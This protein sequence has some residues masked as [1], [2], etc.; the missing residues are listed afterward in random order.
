MC[1]L[2]DK[3]PGCTAAPTVKC[4]VS[5]ARYRGTVLKA[6]AANVKGTARACRQSCEYAPALDVPALKLQPRPDDQDRV[7][8][9]SCGLAA[10]RRMVTH[11]SIELA[12]ASR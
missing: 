8:C 4:N 1:D 9:S 3:L 6:G 2:V 10:Q 11:S 5:A 12:S 7:L